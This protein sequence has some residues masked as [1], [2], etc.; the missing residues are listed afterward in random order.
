MPFMCAIVPLLSI[1]CASRLFWLW[2]PL[3]GSILDVKSSIYFPAQCPQGA[4]DWLLLLWC[5]PKMYARWTLHVRGVVLIGEKGKAKGGSVSVSPPHQFYFHDQQ[6]MASC[7]ATLLGWQSQ[8]THLFIV[9]GFVLCC[10]SNW[11]EEKQTHTLSHKSMK[12]LR[13]ILFYCHLTVVVSKHFTSRTKLSMSIL[14]VNASYKL[15]SSAPRYFF[16]FI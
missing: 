6:L 15:S 4:F 8:W 9:T 14:N 1:L 12:Y 3:V 10:Q 13:C 2:L 16:T 7:S 11:R 5:T